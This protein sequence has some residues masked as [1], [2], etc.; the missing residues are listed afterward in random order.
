MKEKA[1]K[2]SDIDNFSTFILI[3]SMLQLKNLT[4]PKLLKTAKR[5]QQYRKAG[6]QE[7]C[8]R[9]LW[10]ALLFYLAVCY[11]F[12]EGR[13]L[14]HRQELEVQ[15][16]QIRENPESPYRRL[17][18]ESRSICEAFS[19]V[20]Q[21]APQKYEFSI[22]ETMGRGGFRQIST[23]KHILISQFQMCYKCNMDVMGITSPDN[24]DICFC[25]DEGITW[26]W[27][28][29]GKQ[30]QVNR[31]ETFISRNRH[32]LERTCYQKDRPFNFIGIKIPVSR[33]QEI[34]GEYGLC[35]HEAAIEKSVGCFTKHSMTPSV[36]VILQQ[37]LGCPYQNAMLEMYTDGKLLELLS[38]YFS[39]VVQQADPAAGSPLLLSRTDRE[40][41]Q[42]AK[43][44]LDHS[45]AN[46]P[47]CTGLARMVYLNETKL[48]R[49]FKAMF[50][51][52]VHRYV[53]DR[54]LETALVLFEQGD[55]Q[56]ST[57]AG[58][59][60]YGNMSHFSAAFKK[61]YGIN[62]R[63]YTRKNNHT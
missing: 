15:G 53:I 46:P 44:I 16:M 26:E 33:F 14:S 32:G 11:N 49:G 29:E 21:I 35:S 34:L 31:G 4:H 60:G 28:K 7:L 2:L 6:Y 56:I 42:T 55:T 48:A 19:K 45:I 52:T 39:Q 24:I 12:G 18:P 37:L 10:T 1:L 13:F 23:R 8:W 63:E 20:T 17:L 5:I 30:L 9:I 51:M 62:P 50:G 43:E 54:R 22:P 27:G 57:V 61:K 47:T 58:M 41:L 36:K 3:S 59:V 25:L 40:S 38:V